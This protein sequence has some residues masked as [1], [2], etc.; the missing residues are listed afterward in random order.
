MRGFIYSQPIQIDWVYEAGLKEIQL[1]SPLQDSTG[2]L[3]DSTLDFEWETIKQKL[4]VSVRYI[5]KFSRRSHCV[6]TP[7][8]SK[9]VVPGPGEGDL[10]SAGRR[11]CHAAVSPVT[12]K[13][14]LQ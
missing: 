3:F 1:V 7:V 9:L 12:S 11:P 4:N 5:E 6:L 8:I 10:G 14:A 13:C 2:F